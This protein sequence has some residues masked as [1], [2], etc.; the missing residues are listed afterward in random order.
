MQDII[1][2]ELDGIDDDIF[3]PSTAVD[4]AAFHLIQTL[5]QLKS[6][7]EVETK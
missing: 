4:T 6:L 7:L 5:N 2:G 3:E 1:K